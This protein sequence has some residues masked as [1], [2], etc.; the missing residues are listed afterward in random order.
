[1]EPVNVGPYVLSDRDKAGFDNQ[2]LEPLEGFNNRKITW[3]IAGGESGS[4]ARPCNVEWIR[5]IVQDCEE[6]GCA[7]FVKQLG[8]KPVCDCSVAVESFSANCCQHFP[9]PIR[10]KKGGKISEWPEDL[11]IQQWPKGF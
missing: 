5:A 9:Y 4:N 3:C 11:R 6:Y 8:A 2:F 10:D 1:L 7:C